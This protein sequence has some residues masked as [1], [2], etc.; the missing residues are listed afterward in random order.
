MTVYVSVW[1][2]LWIIR[3]QLTDDSEINSGVASWRHFEVDSAAVESLVAFADVGQDE[4]AGDLSGG[5]QS[6]M[7]S[8][9][10]HVSVG[11]VATLS[12]CVLARI[13]TARQKHSIKSRDMASEALNCDTMA[14]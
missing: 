6:E 11:P 3:E 10:Q 12:Q 8:G 4:P 13:E 7:R 5:A 14:H 9:A 1:P 2:L